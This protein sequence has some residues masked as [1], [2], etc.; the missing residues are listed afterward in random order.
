[1][2]MCKYKVVISDHLF[3]IEQDDSG[4]GEKPI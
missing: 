1:M 4:E 2:E 3:K